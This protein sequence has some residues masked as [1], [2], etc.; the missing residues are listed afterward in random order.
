MLGRGVLSVE[1]YTGVSASSHSDRTT[2][3]TYDGNGDVLTLVA[4]PMRTQNTAYIY[5]VGGTVGSSLFSNDV[6]GK[7]EYPDP[8]TGQARTAASNDQS[9]GY[10]LLGEKTSFTDQNGTIHV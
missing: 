3:S 5:G 8:V 2:A 4:G 6:I 10:N 1:A 9:F 7:I